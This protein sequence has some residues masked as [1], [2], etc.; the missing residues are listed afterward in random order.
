[1]LHDGSTV[2]GVIALKIGPLHLQNW[3]EWG[4]GLKVQECYMFDFKVGVHK[5]IVSYHRLDKFDTLRFNL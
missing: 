3:E 5:H 4:S 2:S 1:M